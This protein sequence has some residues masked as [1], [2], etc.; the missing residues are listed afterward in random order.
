MSRWREAFLALRNGVD[1]QVVLRTLKQGFDTYDPCDT[2]QK[3]SESGVKTSCDTLRHIE[4][5]PVPSVTS[6][7]TDFDS[8]TPGIP[9]SVT[10]VTTVKGVY[11]DFETRNTSGCNLDTAG[12]WRYAADPRTEVL[13]L[14]YKL[15]GGAHQLWLPSLGWCDPLASLA[16]DASTSFICFAGFELAVWQRIMVERLGFPSIPIGRWI[17][18]QAECS[19]FAVP[20]TLGKVLPVIGAPVAKDEAGKRLVRR[21]SKRDRKTGEYPEV[22]PEILERVA[23][24]NQIDV[25]GLIAVH[26]AF[27]SL[28]EQERRVWELDQRI[29]QRGL[30]IDVELVRAAKR[31]SEISTSALLEEF[32]GLTR[33]LSPYQVGKTREWLTGR[34]FTLENIQEETVQAALDELTL[35]EDV[36]RVL[37]IR[38]ITAS[39]SLK[40]LDAMLACVGS[41]GRA[42]GLLRY[43]AATPGRWSAELIQPQNLPRPTVEIEDS[44]ELVAAVK[45]GDPKALRRWG[46]PLEVLASALRFAVCAEEGSL[47]G[48]ADFSAIEACVLLALA[49]QHDKCSLI[50]GGVDIY[51]DMAAMIYGLDRDRFLAIR[52]EELTLEQSEQ[53]RIGKNT[54]LGCGFSMGGL[55][56]RNQYLRH[57]PRQEGEKLAAGIVYTHYRKTWAPKVPQLWRDLEA[58]AHRAMLHP[59]I[60]IK[61][62]CGIVYTLDKIAGLPTLVCRLLNGKHI[63]YVNARVDANKLDPYGN[64]VWTYWAYRKGQ[65]REIDPYGGQLT[66]NVVQALARE[67]LVD[68]M[69][70]FEERGYQIVL[71]V[72]DEVLIEHPQ[73]TKMAMENIMVERPGWAEKIG[74]PL[75]AKA[76][77][78]KRY[79]K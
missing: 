74:V 70:A 61:A 64:P 72:H 25:D 40:K 13:T 15:D 26:T 24:Y 18:A 67:L 73:I 75:A 7:A 27:G 14:T 11:L 10:S 42:R 68:R 6:V 9:P 3:S 48:A 71:T 43:H 29:N 39:T 46:E 47:F 50:A 52:E 32:A 1:P 35:P 37:E 4:S 20:R 16:A 78:G 62:R 41:D 31:I 22:T 77:V 51:R 54:V 53:R 66:E 76:W 12:A 21:L 79:R 34:G 63:H 60:P 8:K 49:G 2:W 44:E 57:L 58:S 17:D 38:L 28:S 33:G 45:T 56:F 36:R 5:S 65:W 55:R 59:G 23:A 69:F 30:G 19:Y